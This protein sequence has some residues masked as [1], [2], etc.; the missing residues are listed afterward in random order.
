MNNS[1]EYHLIDKE[2]EDIRAF[3]SE[4]EVIDFVEKFYGKNSSVARILIIT[5]ESRFWR[6]E[7]IPKILNTLGN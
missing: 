7:K 3:F 6:L 4:K 1:I 5:G 2:T